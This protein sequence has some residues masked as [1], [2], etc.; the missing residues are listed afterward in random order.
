MPSAEVAV[1]WRAAATSVKLHR[2]ALVSTFGPEFP[3]KAFVVVYQSSPIW[4]VHRHED[5][6]VKSPFDYLGPAFIHSRS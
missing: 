4:S 5:I 6:G 1:P 2:N 3:Q